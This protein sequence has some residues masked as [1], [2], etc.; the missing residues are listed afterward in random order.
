MANKAKIFV[1]YHINEEPI[2]SDIY[3]P[4]AVGP[5]KDSFPDSFLRDDIGE[6]IAD[7]NSY[8]N[9]M[10]AIYWVYKHID[11]FKDIDYIG[12]THYRRL[13]CFSHLDRS[14]YVKKNLDYEYIDIDNDRLERMFKDYDL[15][16][17][18]PNRYKS[19]RRHYEKAHNKEDID[20]ITGLIKKF[21]PEYYKIAN[22]YFLNQYEYSY[23]MFVFKKD[24]FIKYGDFVFTILEEFEKIKENID[25][26]YISERLTGVFISYLIEK[27]ETVL[28][29][30]VLHIRKKSLKKSTEEVNNNF[31]K[32]TDNGFLYKCKSLLL[33]LMPRGVEQYLRRRK[34]K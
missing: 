33:Y 31:K 27:G 26:M 19:V 7:K 32:G 28:K 6:N 21:K 8:Y 23:N 12:F 3:T 5:H 25:R 14:V 11:E 17:P 20:I 18:Y 13:F 29:L 24:D 30:P 2:Q 22:E 15:I 10:T 4:I 1:I 16:A 9:E 34:T